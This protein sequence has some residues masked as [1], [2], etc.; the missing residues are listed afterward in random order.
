MHREADIMANTSYVKK[1]LILSSIWLIPVVTCSA[2]HQFQLKSLFFALGIILSA[3]AVVML[4]VNK[5]RSKIFFISLAVFAAYMIFFVFGFHTKTL[6]DFVPDG[7]SIEYVEIR[8]ADESKSV[9]WTPGGGS[10][11]ITENDGTH[12]SIEGGSAEDMMGL[13]EEITLRDYWLT[14]AEAEGKISDIIIYLAADGGE[15]SISVYCMDKEAT[16]FFHEKG[17]SSSSRWM[18]FDS[19]DKLIPSEVMGLI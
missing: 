17:K 7:Y 8:M 9:A 11:V 16:I 19:L 1:C 2:G 3:A 14:G 5:K 18:I 6:A 4:C 13:M 15:F 12:I 10:P